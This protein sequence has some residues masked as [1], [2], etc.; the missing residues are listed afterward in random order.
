MTRPKPIRREKPP[1]P[2]S[3][4]R[5][6][7]GQSARVSC[8]GHGQRLYRQ[9]LATTDDGGRCP[10]RASAMLKIVAL[11]VTV[12]VGDSLN[13]ST[14]GPA[15]FLA[16]GERARIAVLE[17]ILAVF[18]VHFSGGV[19]LLLGPG[20][21]LLSLV[22]RLSHMTRDALE[23]AAGLAL[24][25]A[26]G[27]IWHQRH[28][29]AQQTLPTP[30]PQRKSSILLG[31]V[32]I[33]I[34]LPTAFPYFAAITAILGAA[35]D[36]PAQLS[37]LALYNLCFILPLVAVLI[38]LLLAGERAAERLIRVREISER[39]WPEVFAAVLFV[40][41]LAVAGFAGAALSRD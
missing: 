1:L 25:L 2:A 29:L 32:I 3:R 40:L 17:F 9:R 41:G 35:D 38:T 22:N 23:L 10:P 18:V 39:R 31:A 33:V 16:S 14:I 24:L 21:L 34:E 28:R 13:P 15:L 12:A 30:S 4:S 8:T 26:G 6:L 19:I 11:V 36:T 7:G 37:L 20:H 27:V 5:G